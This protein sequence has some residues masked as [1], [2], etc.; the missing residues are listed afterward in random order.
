MNSATPALLALL[1]VISFPA[2]PVAAAGPGAEHD[3]ATST[4]VNA[5]IQQESQQNT[6][7]TQANNTTNRLSLSGKTRSEHVRYRNDLGTALASADDELRI[8]YGQYALVD[9]K[10]DRASTAKQEKLVQT[11]YNQLKDRIDT[12]ESRERKAVRAHA[13]GDRSTTELLQTLSRN[14]HEATVISNAL[15]TLADRA[16]RIPG[17]SLSVRDEQTELDMHQTAVHS[18]LETMGKYPSSNDELIAVKTSTTGYTLEMIHGEYI[19]ETTRFDNRDQTRPNQFGDITDAHD[20]AKKLYPWVFE[21]RYSSEAIES[22]TVQLYQIRASHDQGQLVSYLDGGTRNV[23]REIQRLSLSSLPVA[24]ET[25]WTGDDLTLSVSETPANGPVAVTVVDADSGE[26]KDA[27]IT[28]DGV[29]VGQ[30]GEDGTLWI[31]PP[32]DKYD[33]TVETAAESVTVSRSGNETKN[34]R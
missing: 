22:R 17:Y 18:R 7:L 21:T 24:D 8:A 28:V 3:V 6:T 33:I 4:A 9:S 2:A 19:R 15:D 32:A 31:V 5:A 27:T 23:H 20:T 12:L 11:A 34:G 30:T 29:T 1:L 14:Y 16:D 25:R 10:F 13:N 26:P